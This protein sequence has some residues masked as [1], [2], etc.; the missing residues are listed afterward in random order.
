MDNPYQDQNNELINLINILSFVVGLQNMQENR[1]QSA[2]NDVQ[3]ANDR[4]AEYLLNEI[5]R[6]FDEQNGILE[7]QNGMLARLL[8][9]LEGDRQK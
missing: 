6:R 7:E 5:N 8:E 1:L 4:Q 3:A 9:L 2:Q